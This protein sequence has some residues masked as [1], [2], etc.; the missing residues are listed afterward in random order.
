MV[1][2]AKQEGC[3]LR[4]KLVYW[5][6]RVYPECREG[7]TLREKTKGLSWAPKD[8]PWGAKRRRERSHSG[9]VQ[10]FTKPPIR[11]DSR[12]RISPSPQRKKFPLEISTLLKRII[13]KIIHLNLLVSPNKQS[14][15]L[16]VCGGNFC[17]L[18]SSYLL[19]QQHFFLLPI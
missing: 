3:I 17:F 15:I 18:P 7:F 12:V 6:R 8:L 9:R 1:K 5:W 13:S 11:K 14:G 19:F 16:H 10:W 2:S 4:S